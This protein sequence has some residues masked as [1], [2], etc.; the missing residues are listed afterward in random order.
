MEASNA[1]GNQPAAPA[2]KPARRWL[3]AAAFAAGGLLAL[4]VASTAALWWWAGS[5]GSLATA[6]RWVGQSQPLT[7]E[8]ATGSL[9]V[10][11][12]IG[13][14]QWQQDGLTV[15]ASDVH[16]AWQPWSLWQGTL[17][18][19]R[20][21]AASVQ[22]TDLRPP[23]TPIKPPTALG[24]PVRVELDQFRVGQLELTGKAVFS[25]SDI[26]GN[27]SYTG[28]K[29]QLDLKSAQVASGRYSAKAT[30]TS[31]G[32]LML[33]AT[34]KGALAV[35]VPSIAEPVPLSFQATANGPLT[36]LIVKAELQLTAAAAADAKK[37]VPQPHAS[38]S[39]RVTP[40]AAQPVPQADATFRDL[41]IGALWPQAPQ[42]LLTGSASVRPLENSTSAWALALQLD[43][44]LP[45]PWDQHRLPIE[46]L[47]TQGEWRDGAALVRS[48]KAQ[49][50]GGDIV[51][52][53]EWSQTPQA[54]KPATAPSAV[55][56]Q[57]W[58]LS[59]ALKH[60]N[61]TRLHS[62]LAPLPL[63]GRADVSG[64]GAITRFNASVQ[65]VA[66]A[67]T[68]GS[69]PAPKTQSGKNNFLAQLSLRDAKASG[70]W[71]SQ[72]A[73]GTL[74]LSDLRVRTDDAELSGQVEVQPAFKSGQGKLAL[75]APGLD[76]RFNGELRQ[77]S[78]GGELSVHG[79]DAAQA[80]RWLQKLPGM[81]AAVVNAS[82]SGSAELQAQWQGGW[83]DPALQARLDV[84]TLD[85]LAATPKAETPTQP[86][87]VTQVPPAAAAAA[88][89]P[90][91]LKI[92]ALQ[93]TL[94]GRMSQ[95]QLAAQGR[96]EIDQRRYALQVQADGGR[97]SPAG[98]AHAPLGESAW[99]GLVK[100]L[101]LG[102]EDPT[103]GSG[104]WRLVTR[105]PVPLKWTPARA[106]GTFESGAGEALLSA[107][108]SKTSTPAA[109]SPATLS[110]QPLRW[111]PGE[112]VT[113]GKITGLPLA[114]IELLAGPQLTGAG[115]GG[116]LVFD[117]QWDAVLGDSLRIK[118]SL[119]R[120]S[121]DLTVQAEGVQ[122]NS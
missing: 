25:A 114:W 94:T 8:R 40:W 82:A 11:G 107:P 113:A 56:A 52:S 120:S 63:D 104:A 103:L 15:T 44:A 21:A 95:A 118:A 117:G 75:T 68:T 18:L 121:G 109:Q 49:L 85:W 12:H 105:S 88:A 6:L 35:A 99:Q 17:K 53:G 69:R 60:I 93:A 48:L 67:V 89:S 91:P 77:S 1:P 50:G 22:V 119:A 70:S 45:G 62:Q 101:S 23:S 87:S 102:V 66:G 3:R 74:A 84:P 38:A 2:A 71:N 92:R 61:P 96:V 76:A 7:A 79:R 111:R 26:A 10:G 36:E 80:L 16:L 64:Q 116:S 110:W 28:L 46:Q 47:E 55:P 90:G 43:N 54:D 100:Q 33:D 13:Q 29:H 112:L 30:L 108:P 39:A 51:A 19:D 97:I 14:L 42:T 4:A 20:L 27:Y 31:A 86:A 81:P 106:G 58:K 41:D 122:G 5:E 59:A 65:T 24:L 98:A 73:G 34:V 9:R 37:S 115:L 72:A 32:P 78:G 57:A 83:L